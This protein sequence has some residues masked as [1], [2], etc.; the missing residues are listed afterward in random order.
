[1][2]IFSVDQMGYYGMF[3]GAYIPEMLH[4]NIQ[5]LK[6]NYQKI[7]DSKEFQLEF[8]SLLKDYVGRPTPLYYAK[9]LSK[10]YGASIYLKRED[11]CHTGAHKINNALGQII[12]AKK[13]NKTRIIAETGAGQH[14]VAT[15]TACALMGM[16]CIVYMGEKDIERQSPNVNRM[17]MLGAK[18]EPVSS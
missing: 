13:M 14:G 9:R 11:L 15:A 2:S 6:S 12:L 17:R 7:I 5:Q 16:E 8:K 1:M 10:H 18:V 3:G 4:P